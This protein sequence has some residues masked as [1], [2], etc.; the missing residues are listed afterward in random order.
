MLDVI[1]TENLVGFEGDSKTRGNVTIDKN[2]NGTFDGKTETKMGAVYRVVQDMAIKTDTHGYLIR[3]NPTFRKP[4]SVTIK[5]KVKVAIE[6]DNF[7]LLDDTG[8]EFKFRIMTKVLLEK[9]IDDEWLRIRLL[10]LLD[11]K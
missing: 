10:F 2:G 4:A 1:K 6:K 11:R 7:Y 3:Q 9:E 5:G 8:K